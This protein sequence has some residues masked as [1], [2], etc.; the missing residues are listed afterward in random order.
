M[1]HVEV[2]DLGRSPQRQAP[3]HYTTRFRVEATGLHLPQEWRTEPDDT[4]H[5]RVVGERKSHCLKAAPTVTNKS[6]AAEFAHRTCKE[7]KLA[8]DCCLHIEPWP[9]ACEPLALQPMAKRA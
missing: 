5:M 2:A 9:M 7:I 4:A 8:V 3:P 6:T 1:T